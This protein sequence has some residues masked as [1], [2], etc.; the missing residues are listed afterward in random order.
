MTTAEAPDGCS[1]AREVIRGQGR[2]GQASTDARKAKQRPRRNQSTE[3]GEDL[4]QRE[5]A[6]RL[7]PRS[8]H[9]GEGRLCELE[10][11]GRA[12]ATSLP[13]GHGSARTP[14]PREGVWNEGERTCDHR[15]ADG[16]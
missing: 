15:P 4:S 13:R 1:A 7:V 6:L 9:R 8:P 3:W 16:R 10:G 2:G 11:H 5:T 14:G 12:G